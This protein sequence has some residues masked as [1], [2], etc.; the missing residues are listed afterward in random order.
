LP[1]AELIEIYARAHG[2]AEGAVDGPEG[3]S[4]AWSDGRASFGGGYPPNDDTYQGVVPIF[5]G[6]LLGLGGGAADATDGD[7]RSCMI[8]AEMR[9][10]R[11]FVVPSSPEETPYEIEWRAIPKVIDVEWDARQI[12]R[13]EKALPAQPPLARLLG[14]ACLALAYEAIASDFALLSKVRLSKVAIRRAVVLRERAQAAH[15]A[16]DWNDDAIRSLAQNQDLWLLVHVGGAELTVERTLNELLSME[17]PLSGLG[18]L[19]LVA[20]ALRHDDALARRIVAVIAEAPPRAQ[21]VAAM[22]LQMVGGWREALFRW[23]PASD[24]ARGV[25]TFQRMMDLVHAAGA[26]EQVDTAAL[27]A[28]QRELPE[29]WIDAAKGLVEASD[30]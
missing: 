25:K 19:Y 9:E 8:R 5:A 13:L 30:E 27:A 7:D 23:A 1:A 28:I 24:L 18:L 22:Q 16:I 11:I 4:M 10:Q 2:L 26:P 17:V 12:H 14:T 15:A 29:A 3:A 21:F 6:E 20:A